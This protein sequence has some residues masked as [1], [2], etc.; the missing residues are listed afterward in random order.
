MRWILRISVALVVFVMLILLLVM[1]IPA[2]RVARLA[3]DKF[4]ELS[5]RSLTFEGEVSPRFWPVLGVTTGPVSISNAEWSGLEGPM[6][7]AD[8]LMIS[9]NAAALVGGEVK[10]LGIEAERPRI[11]LE[12]DNKGRENWVFGGGG[13]GGEI[14]E[15]TP[16][17]GRAWTLEKGLISNGTLRFVD[18]I[19]GR[20]ITLDGLNAELAIP[21][22]GG[23]FTTSASAVVS[24]QRLTLNATGGIFSAFTEGRIVPVSLTAGVGDAKLSFEGRGGWQPMAAEG[25]IT[26]DLSDLAALGALSGTSVSAPPEGFGARR[27]ALSGQLTLDDKGALY[28]RGTR[29]EADDNILAGDLD[30][31]QGEAR[32]KLSGNL[33]ANA[34][35]LRGLSGSTGDVAGAGNAAPPASGGEGWSKERIDVSA[36]GAID[37]EVSLGAGSVDLGRLKF[38]ETRLL[39]SIDRSRAVFDISELAAYGGAVTG[40]FVLNGRGGLSVGGTLALAG[41]DTQSLLSDLA[42]WD[43][44]I[45]RVNLNFSFLGVGNSLDELMRGLK[46]EG[47]LSLSKGEIRGLDIAG[48]LRTLDTS[49]VG[50]GQKTIF[51]GIAGSFNILDGNLTNEDLKLMAPYLNAS[52]SG[53]VGLGARDLDYRIRP[54]AFP[55]QDGT[56]G[57][58]VP[59]RITGPWAAPSYRLDLE[60]IAREKMEAEAKAAEAKAR[61]EL[62]AKL[63]KELGVEAGQDEKLEDAVKRRARE[64]LS[65]EAARMLEGLIGGN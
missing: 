33:R 44:L 6:F 39:L 19:S 11:L 55:G 23:A 46:G 50:E 45:S 30:L 32:P 40:E 29:I 47:S 53:R 54:V 4:Q 9:I 62:E 36:L 65:D 37:T 52:G 48:M 34:L 21:D 27:L 61:A 20:D 28:L 2:D 25:K 26:A 49:Y 42:G 41:I 22:F 24:G 14:S 3:A 56:G 51:D 38:G 15:T 58:M 5:G 17:V 59:L 16:G 60:S 57:V 1:M 18:Q 8:S 13:E 63:K 10:I 35:N 43:R 31:R 12:R 64:A 7:A